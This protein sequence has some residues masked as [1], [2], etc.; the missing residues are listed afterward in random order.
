MYMEIGKIWLNINVFTSDEMS[1][2]VENW[3]YKMCVYYWYMCNISN[4]AGN[5][6]KY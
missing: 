4:E 6:L 3:V 1:F 2:M 5:Q